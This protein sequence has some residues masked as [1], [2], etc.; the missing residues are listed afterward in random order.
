[1]VSPFI[2]GI[3]TYFHIISVVGW[4]GTS[5]LFLSTI[6]PSLQKLSP[7]TNGELIVKMFPRLLRHVQVF[8]ILTVIFGPLL[9]VVMSLN[10]AP[11][12]FNLVSPWSVFVTTGASFGIATFLLVFLLMTP[13][14]KK[15]GRLVLQMQQ[16]PQQPPPGE[17]RTLQKRLKI[18][19]PI[20]VIF[21][22]LAEIFMVA[23]AQI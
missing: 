17:F 14:I 7:Q 1:M 20:A 21:L 18:G 11:H 12:V 8:T 3:I 4:F 16:N 23:A 10:G 9:A 13:S 22:L 15:L 2:E 5:L 19:T 6:Q